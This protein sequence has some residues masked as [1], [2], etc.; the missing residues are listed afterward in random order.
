MRMLNVDWSG[1]G[2]LQQQS[3]QH[4]DCIVSSRKTRSQ[5]EGS[6][7]PSAALSLYLDHLH[8]YPGRVIAKSS[9][10]LAFFSTN[11]S[12]TSDVSTYLRW[13][14]ECEQE[15]GW[16]SNFCQ[17][18]ARWASVQPWR[19]AGRRH[20]KVINDVVAAIRNRWYP[21]CTSPCLLKHIEVCCNFLEVKENMDASN[22]PLM[23]FFLSH[24]ISVG[25]EGKYGRNQL[26]GIHFSGAGVL[27][28]PISK[29]HEIFDMM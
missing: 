11:Y 15:S 25:S 22:V 9:F 7:G 1:I 5:V 27:N 17:R 4:A 21:Y 26:A 23:L 12:T 24:V 13:C 16:P 3:V 8:R 10:F 14:S 6:A 20:L 19:Q 28:L 2:L 18:C 29:K